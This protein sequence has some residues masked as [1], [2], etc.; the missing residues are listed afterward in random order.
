MPK[1]KPKLKQRKF[2]DGLA[3]RLDRIEKKVDS[4]YKYAQHSRKLMLLDLNLGYETNDR[5]I[6]EMLRK[7]DSERIKQQQC[8]P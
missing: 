5:Y 6:L 8:A 7:L 2:R 4:I 3:H 1:T